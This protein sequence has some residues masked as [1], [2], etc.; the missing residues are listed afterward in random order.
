MRGMYNKLPRYV[1]LENEKFFINTDFRIFIDFE[2]DMQG[3]NKTDAM[4]KVLRRFYPAFFL[5]LEKKLFKEAVKKFVWF[6]RCGKTKEPVNNGSNSKKTQVFSY[7]YDDLY[8]W[9]AF[10]MHFKNSNGKPI[11]L[12][13]DY[14]HWWKF[15]AMWLSIPSD[16]QF[17][18]I[19]GYRAYSGKDKDLLD[20]KEC[21]KLPPTENEIK[22]QIRRDKIYEI[23]N[24]ISK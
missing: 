8:I 24:N 17:I 20:L 14:I 7:S 4:I 9:G 12:T 16:N 10:N 23:A 6:Y 21:Y 18:K 3:V 19:K 2:E 5:I 1:Y 15:K 11:D 13:K 22:D